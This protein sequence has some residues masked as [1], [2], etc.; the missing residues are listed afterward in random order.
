MDTT[1][2]LRL[3][4]GDIVRFKPSAA[5]VINSVLRRNPDMRAEG[6]QLIY[7]SSRDADLAYPRE[8]LTRIIN[9]DRD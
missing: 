1:K 9:A 6:G 3:N 2:Y 5:W 7:T 4:K 8:L